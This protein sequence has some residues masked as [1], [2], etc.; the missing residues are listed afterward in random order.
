M[1]MK[2]VLQPATTNLHNNTLYHLAE[3]ISNEYRTV[4]VTVASPITP[5]NAQFQLAFDKQRNQ[6]DSFKLL[7]WLLKKFKHN[8][9]TKILA[10][11]DIDAYSSAFDFVFGEAYYQGRIAAVYLP[12]LR[13][14]FYGLKP[15]S[16][17][18][19]ERLVKEAVHELGHIFGFVHC[20]NTRCVMHFSISLH[21]VDTKDRTFCQSCIKKY[22]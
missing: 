20:K 21:C 7:G 1:V 16:S 8:K 15:N 10:L 14:E 4:N 3:D 9:K 2:I 6:C 11:F 19:Y 18:F 22:F 13:Q 12:R 5:D 17:L